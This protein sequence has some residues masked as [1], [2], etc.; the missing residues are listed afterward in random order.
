MAETTSANESQTEATGSDKASEFAP[1]TT[2]ADLDRIIGDRLARERSKYGDY[3]E[4]KAKAAQF[5]DLEEAK[6]T[7]LE[8]V[9]AKL[10]KAE[11]KVADFE[12]AAQLATWKAQ[13][14]EETGVPAS[15][16]AGST[17]EELQAHA[18]LLSPLLASNQ[19]PPAPA[20]TIIRSEGAQDLPLNG[21]GIENA[22]KAALGI[23]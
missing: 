16:L 15:V 22:L 8:K 14:A 13:V 1:I 7:E 9:Q 18:E 17:L 4:L 11:A 21:D 12:H 3:D 5:D 23:A 20:K 6:K 10:A 2:Q 19:E